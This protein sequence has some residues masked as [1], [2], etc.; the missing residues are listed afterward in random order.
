MLAHRD[1]LLMIAAG[2]GQKLLEDCIFERNPLSQALMGVPFWRFRPAL[3]GSSSAGQR[4]RAARVHWHFAAGSPA[5]SLDTQ[6]RAEGDPEPFRPS[7]NPGP[8]SRGFSKTRLPRS[9]FERLY[10]DSISG[11]HQAIYH[12][13]LSG[14]AFKQRTHRT[15]APST[16][17]PSRPRSIRARSAIS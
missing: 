11:S 1:R 14:M 12:Q 4:W 10:R 9:E 16:P 5:P 8:Q 6:P 3:S 13:A 2:Q 7:S 17:C 15:A